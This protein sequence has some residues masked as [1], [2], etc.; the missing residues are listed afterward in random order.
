MFESVGE[1]ADRTVAGRTRSESKA[2]C[3]NRRLRRD[4]TAGL[5]A[6]AGEAAREVDDA[7]P[8]WATGEGCYF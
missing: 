7:L 4:R 8:W 3:T 5:A 2:R 1:A 6:D